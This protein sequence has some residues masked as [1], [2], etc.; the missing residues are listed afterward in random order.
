MSSQ[1]HIMYQGKRHVTM[2]SKLSASEASEELGHGLKSDSP[3]AF[4]LAVGGIL[5]LGKEAAQ[6]AAYLVKDVA[7]QPPA[8]PPPA[9][10]GSNV[11]NAGKEEV[12]A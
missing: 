5:V 11:N 9:D 4:D 3:L 6:K 10:K 1:I 8:V 7:E 12:S 2:P